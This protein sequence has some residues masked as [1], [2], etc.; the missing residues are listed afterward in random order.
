VKNR[1]LK[2]FTKALIAQAPAS[3]AP[4]AGNANGTVVDLVAQP[5][6]QAGIALIAVGAPT[7]TPSSFSCVYKL[8][9]SSDNFSTD[10]TDVASIT[11]T[12]AGIY[13]IPF[14]PFGLSQYVRVRRELTFVSGTSPTLPDCVIIQLGD[15]KYAPLAG[16]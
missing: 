16:V 7:G 1:Y 12:A 8:Q 3:P 2:T 11:V 13:C 5:E 14:E 15:P 9:T 4:G 6:V 10:T